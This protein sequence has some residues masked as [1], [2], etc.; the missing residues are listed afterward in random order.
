[1][2]RSIGN[3]YAWR[4]LSSMFYRR[5][6]NHILCSKTITAWSYPSWLVAEFL[7]DPRRITQRGFWYL[8][9][10]WGLRNRFEGF[11]LEHLTYVLSIFTIRDSSL[12]EY[13]TGI[14][15]SFRWLLLASKDHEVALATNM[16]I[17]LVLMQSSAMFLSLRPRSRVSLEISCV[18]CGLYS[19]N[20]LFRMIST[21]W[22]SFLPVRVYGFFMRLVYKQ[23]FGSAINTNILIYFFSF[24]SQF[25]LRR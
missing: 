23:L 14:C 10:M 16:K 24:N 6:A 22:W 21:D 8:V 2:C 5:T 25:L 15:L 3:V 19:G 1:M 7:S 13:S 18:R 20:W 12:H 9:S 4:S 11:I 17:Q